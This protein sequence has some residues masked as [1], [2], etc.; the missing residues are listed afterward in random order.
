MAIISTTELTPMT[1]PS[2]VSTVRMRLEP[3]ACQASPSIGPNM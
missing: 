2:M 3:I 1:I